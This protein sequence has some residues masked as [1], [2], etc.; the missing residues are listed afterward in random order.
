MVPSPKVVAVQITTPLLASAS[1]ILP[2]HV[3]R[4]LSGLLF[5]VMARLYSANYEVLTYLFSHRMIPEGAVINVQHV[6]RQPSIAASLRARRLGEVGTRFRNPIFGRRSVPLERAQVHRAVLSRGRR[7]RVKS[8]VRSWPITPSA[9]LQH[10]LPESRLSG[11]APQP[12]RGLALA[13]HRSSAR[14]RPMGGEA[15]P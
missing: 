2:S 10:S 12:P 3:V 5:P 14:Y 8:E 13:F 7:C 1:A 4:R 6:Q 15:T 9:A 11:Q